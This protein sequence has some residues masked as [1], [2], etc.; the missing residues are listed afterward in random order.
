MAEHPTFDQR[1]ATRQDRTAEGLVELSDGLGAHLPVRDRQLHA[2]ATLLGWLREA[3]DSRTPLQ[4]VLFDRVI[5]SACG[6]AGVNSMSRFIRDRLIPWWAYN[7][8]S[9]AIH[10]AGFAA[11]DAGSS[12]RYPAGS[13]QRN[14]HDEIVNHP[15]LE[16]SF[17]GERRTLNLRSVLTEAE[18]MLERV[19]EDSTAHRLLAE[20]RRNTASGNATAKWWDRLVRD[21]ARIEARRVRTRN[22][23][24]H[25][26][27]LARA[28]V[29]AVA[30]FAEHLAGEALAACVEGQ[31]LGQDLVDY[32]LDR[33]RRVNRMRA[34]LAAGIAAA[35]VLFW[36]D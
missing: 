4:L 24:T 14:T 1:I 6:W 18:W 26:G 27:P 8:I 3:R 16:A 22:A 25:G 21:A 33:D 36:K 31:L 5:E 13:P 15:P 10:V 2:A 12:A 35:D 32:F 20:L 30:A 7:R 19:P 11:L 28:T 29:E 23:L 34:E 17:G 9:N